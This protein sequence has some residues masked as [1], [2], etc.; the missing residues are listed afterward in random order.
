MARS[1]KKRLEEAVSGAQAN[2]GRSR[3]GASNGK[4]PSASSTRGQHLCLSSFNTI[5]RRHRPEVELL[6]ES[7]CLRLLAR[8][9][10]EPGNAV[11]HRERV[12]N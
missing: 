2:I 6:E 4:T 1:E 8:F 11:G 10:S 7:A 9:P 5:T 12:S 3:I